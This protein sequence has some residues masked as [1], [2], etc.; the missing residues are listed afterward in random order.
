M[1]ILIIGAGGIIGNRVSEELSRRHEIIKAGR[2]ADVKVDIESAD[3]IKAMFEKTGSIDACVI[4]AG[5]VYF[6]DFGTMTEKNM[7]EGIKSK[8]MGQVNTV[9]IGQKYIKNSFTLTSGILSE[10]PVRYS[11]SAALVNGGLN[12]FVISASRE[13]KTR[14]NIVSPGVVEDAAEKYEGFFPG[15]V[16]AEMR[17]VVAAYVKSVEGCATGE[18]I[19]VY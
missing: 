9:L 10:D 14:I 6:G 11:A 1:K 7:Y 4:A 15:H 19:K 12:S 2:N 17:K 3:S 16:P 18:I 13:L 8:L 5:S